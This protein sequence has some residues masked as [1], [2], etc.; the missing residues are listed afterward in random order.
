MRCE[1]LGSTERSADGT[2][3]AVSKRFCVAKPIPPSPPFKAKPQNYGKKDEMRTTGFDAAKRR[4]DAAGGLE[5]ILRSKTNPSFSAIWQSQINTSATAERDEN[6]V[7]QS[8]VRQSEAQMGRRRRSRRDFAQQHQSLI[9]RHLTQS[10]QT[11]AQRER[12]ENHCSARMQQTNVM[13]IKHIN[14]C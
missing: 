8:E 11:L 7:R 12:N 6:E 5:E 13:K 1:P 3:Q 9:L 10:K 4:W 2:P 14:Y